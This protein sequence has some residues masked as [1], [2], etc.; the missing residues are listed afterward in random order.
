MIFANSLQMGN[1][2]GKFSLSCYFNWVGLLKCNRS[3]RCSFLCRP[4][5]KEWNHLTTS[6][7]VVLNLRFVWNIQLSLRILKRQIWHESITGCPQFFC[8]SKFILYSYRIILLTSVGQVNHDVTGT[9]WWT[10]ILYGVILELW[11]S[12]KCGN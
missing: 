2:N 10:K 11:L 1:F 12:K 9:W 3:W 4:R 7:I 5:R 6:V 8:Y